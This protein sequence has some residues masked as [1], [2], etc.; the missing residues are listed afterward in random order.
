MSG[1]LKRLFGKNFSRNI[2][3]RLHKITVKY[4]LLFGLH[5]LCERIEDK[6][7]KNENS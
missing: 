3:L 4:T 1:I 2:Q 5:G 7:K 6:T